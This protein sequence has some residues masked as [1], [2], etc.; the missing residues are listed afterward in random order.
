MSD[1]V[2]VV[3][4]VTTV[5]K[6]YPAGGSSQAGGGEGRAGEGGAV[7]FARALAK[8]VNDPAYR[9][10][11]I[12]RPKTLVEDFVNL[13]L[14]EL[15]IL[16]STWKAAEGDTEGVGSAAGDPEGYCCCCCCS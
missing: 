1:D 2:K 8:L 12:R 7:D 16:I 4:T 14:I 3:T 11:V 6:T 5:T 13:T 10:K 15:G 9:A